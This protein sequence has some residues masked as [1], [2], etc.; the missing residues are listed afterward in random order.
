MIITP[1]RR[2]CMTRPANAD[3]FSVTDSRFELIIRLTV[4]MISESD[5]IGLGA[6]PGPGL[7]VVLWAALQG[8]F[9]LGRPG[10]STAPV[11]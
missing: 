5:Q 9:H 4:S 7:T 1:H 6:A 8:N 11:L 10:G 2:R 3:H